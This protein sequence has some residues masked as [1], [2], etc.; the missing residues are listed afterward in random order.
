LEKIEIAVAE[1]D[2]ALLSNLNFRNPDAF[3]FNI[4]TSG[5]EEIRAILTY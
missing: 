2:P 4:I 1:F 3:K 5:L